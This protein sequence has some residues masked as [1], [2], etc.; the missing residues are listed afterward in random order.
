MIRFSAHFH[1]KAKKWY[2]KHYYGSTFIGKKINEKGQLVRRYKQ[3]YRFEYLDLNWNE[4]PVTIE[5][6]DTN[7]KTK[8]LITQKIK[9]LENQELEKKVI[10]TKNYFS[11]GH[12]ISLKKRKKIMDQS[13]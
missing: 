8:N 1:K 5:E 13:I 6:K 2:I 4:F 3:N 7:Q 10:N 12:S 11:L 9:F